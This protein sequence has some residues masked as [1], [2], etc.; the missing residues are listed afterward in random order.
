[1]LKTY[2]E[3]DL[4]SVTPSSIL[5]RRIFS[6]HV[7]P[8]FRRWKSQSINKAIVRNRGCV[9]DPL[10]QLEP[11]VYYLE[12]VYSVSIACVI[13]HVPYS[14]VSLFWEIVAVTPGINVRHRYK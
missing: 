8:I 10:I 2:V 3:I 5:Q 12:L 14:V 6:S 11:P 13:S 7:N 4:D 1:M 9:D